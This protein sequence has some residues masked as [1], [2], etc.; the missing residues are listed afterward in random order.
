MFTKF[1]RKQVNIYILKLQFKK[2]HR[3]HIKFLYIFRMVICPLCRSE[4]RLPNNGFFPSDITRVNLLEINSRS[5]TT[6]PD[7]VICPICR[8]KHRNPDN[9]LLEI[10]SLSLTDKRGK[11]FY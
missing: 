1:S 7:I 8:S 10:N 4:H 11:K 5:I 9:G 3:L 6:K 2:L